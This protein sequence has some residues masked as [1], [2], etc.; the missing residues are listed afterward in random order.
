MLFVE[1]GVLEGL[2]TAP[3]EFV[4]GLD[5][6]VD[7]VDAAA[8]AAADTTATSKVPPETTAPCPVTSPAFVSCWNV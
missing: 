7:V 8:A 6:A 2:I 1:D 4:T 5:E 3:L